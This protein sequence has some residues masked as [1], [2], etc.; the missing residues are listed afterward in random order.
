MTAIG[1]DDSIAAHGEGVRPPRVS[2]II[3]A[4][5]HELYVGEAI[6][7]VL[8][9]SWTDLE[10]IIIDD[11][12]SDATDARIRVYD[13]PR[14][15]YTTQVNIGA[16]PTINLGIAR[17]RGEFIN[18][19]NSDDVYAPDRIE[20]LVAAFDRDEALDAQVT[21]LEFI[22]GDGRRIGIREC[23]GHVW[24]EKAAVPSFAD[25]DELVLHLLAGNFACTTSN[26]A[27]RRRVFD[28]IGAFV[29]LRYLHDYEFLLRLCYR[30]KVRVLPE[31]L[32]KYR[33]HPQ[34]T[35]KENEGQT[36]FEFGTVLATFLLENDLTRFCPGE[37]P[38]LT[39]LK[40]FNTLTTRS[41]ARLLITSLVLGHHRVLDSDALH[42]LAETKQGELRAACVAYSSGYVDTWA[43]AQ[44][45]W[46]A[47]RKANARV[48]ELEAELADRVAAGDAKV[49]ELLEENKR[50]F[51]E[52][53]EVRAKSDRVLQEMQE[54]RTENERVF[55]ESQELRTESERV[56]RESQELRSENERVFRESQ[57]LRAENERVFR[58]SQELRAE[59]ERVFRESQE[60]R[61]EN[62]RVFRESQELKVEN[63][64]VFRESQELKVE[65]ERVF[66]E[67]QELRA[68]NERVT[69]ES[70]ALRAENERVVSESQS[71]ASEHESRLEAA[72]AEVRALS[73]ELA[74]ARDE[75]AAVRGELQ[76]IWA[77]YSWRIA[78][79]LTWPLRLLSARSDGSA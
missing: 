14:I 8:N 19:L 31:V 22:D 48:E 77:S 3:P 39:A 7:S 52:S 2:V 73:D 11:G 57:E 26:I 71:L 33:I 24:R 69:S 16:A 58:E 54:L 36:D 65:N 38:E 20:K 15:H 30:R 32:V 25:A 45:G 53:Q 6:E 42:A 46:Q 67:S 37:D 4:Y 59:N 60:L 23:P 21:H 63:E 74:A 50:V 78:R 10:L 61:A 76:R 34:N 56:F 41:A 70:Q 13:D 18:I 75:L 28:A 66:R 49:M 72:R 5:N 9:Q 79:A 12:S 17:A 1:N 68:E 44:E 47:W 64:R 27:C 29:D 62:E 43:S 40:F 51:G 55:R 35:I